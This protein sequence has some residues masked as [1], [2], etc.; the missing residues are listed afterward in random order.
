[1]LYKHD[2]LYFEQVF[3]PVLLVI[4]DIGG[5]YRSQQSSESLSLEGHDGCALLMAMSVLHEAYR[6]LLRHPS[7]YH[8]ST[9][10]ATIKFAYHIE[11]Y[12]E[13]S[14]T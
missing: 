9:D 1:M 8:S 2:A 7:P 6:K 11:F 10:T 14:A 3:F 12:I 5:G 13:S 4:I